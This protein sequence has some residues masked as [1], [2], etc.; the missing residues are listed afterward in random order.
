MVESLV[1][2]DTENWLRSLSLHTCRRSLTHSFSWCCISPPPPSRE[3]DGF[4]AIFI[5]SPN[6]IVH[7]ISLHNVGLFLAMSRVKNILT[8]QKKSIMR[9]CRCISVRETS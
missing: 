5:F 4:G 6:N 2:V 8:K 9:V 7:C 3:E 1:D